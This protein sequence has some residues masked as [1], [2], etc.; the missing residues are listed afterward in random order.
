M[1]RVRESIV[2]VESNMY[3]T[4]CVCVALVI[5]HAKSVRPVIMLYVP[6]VALP[7]FCTLSHKRHDFRKKNYVCF[8]FI[9]KFYLKHFSFKE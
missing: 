7:K 8:D 4:F 1:R 2:A 9:Y 6:S 3:Y 5:Q